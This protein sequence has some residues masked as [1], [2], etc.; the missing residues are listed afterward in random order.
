MSKL[1]K[2]DKDYK[3]WI[4][5]ISNKFRQNQLK[6]AFKANNLMLRF[7]WSVGRDIS[8]MSEKMDMDRDFTK[9]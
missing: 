4:V 1:I 2:V 5:E 7:Y 6:A 9:L 8:A 3:E